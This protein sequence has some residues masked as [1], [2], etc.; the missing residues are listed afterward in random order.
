[1]SSSYKDLEKIPK[2]IEELFHNGYEP[3]DEQLLALGKD[4]ANAVKKSLE[5]RDR[6][7]DGLRLSAI[8]K[9][10]RQLWFTA[11]AK[12]EGGEAPLPLDRHLTYLVGSVMEEVLLFLVEATGKYTV[13]DKQQEVDVDGV[14]GHTDCKING[15]GVD[16]KTAAKY[17]FDEKFVRKGLKDNDPFGYLHQISSYFGSDDKDGVGFLAFCKDDG[18]LYFSGFSKEELPKAVERVSYVKKMVALPEPP[19]ERC[20]ELKEKKNGNIQVPNNCVWCPFF[21]MCYKGTPLRAFDYASGV[22]YYTEVK[23]EP[24]T[25]ELEPFTLKPLVSNKSL[26][27]PV[28]NL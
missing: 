1:M 3:T 11:N 22:E 4:V 10:D 13:T 8:G 2:D 14:I 6:S 26:F 21:E 23:S 15:I 17:S 18:R 5:K 20:Y 16:V 9:P 19:K 12:G 24:K 27:K 7:K 28:K 25:N